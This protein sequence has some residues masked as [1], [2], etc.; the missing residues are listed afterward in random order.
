MALSACCSRGP[1]DAQSQGFERRLFGCRA[2][3]GGR[4]AVAAGAGLRRRRGGAECGGPGHRHRD[5]P[6][7]FG[8]GGAH[9]GLAP[10]GPDQRPRPRR[11]GTH[12]RGHARR[13]Q[14]DR[15]ADDRARHEQDRSPVAPGPAARGD[16]L[17]IAEVMKANQPRINQKGVGFKGFVPAVFGRLVTEQ[18]GLEVDGAA[19]IKITAPPEL[20]RNRKASPDPFEAE[21]IR[22]KFLS[23]GWKKG[24]LY[25]AAVPVKGRPA[26]RVLVPEYYGAGC[27]SC[28]GEPKGEI[29]ITG[30]PK[31]GAKLDQLGGVISI[32]LY[33]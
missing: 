13:D 2:V 4:V 14:G 5:Q 18:F 9:R 30:Y 32:T 28:H 29:D 11:Q 24:E 16:G 7:R 31:E 8:D 23:P 6:R 21:V 22:D 12:P 3:A 17:V 10:P 25:A 15:Q 27:L 26:T 33:K 20:V 19:E 1:A